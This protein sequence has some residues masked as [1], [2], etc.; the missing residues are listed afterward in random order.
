[1]ADISQR[2]VSKTQ[3]RLSGAGGTSRAPSWDDLRTLLA[4][5][6]AGSFRKGAGKLGVDVATAMRRV[7]R[8]E[9]ALD[10]KIVDR[11]PHGLKVLP[12]GESVLAEIKAMEQAAL[13]IRREAGPLEP[14][15]RGLVRVA[16]TEGL[17]TFWVLPRLLEFQ[18]AHRYL[19]FE[20]QTT[21]G[22]TDVGK[23]E[24]DMSV[25]FNRPERQDL[26]AVQI[27]YLHTYP[28]ASQGYARL[29]GL[30][31]SLAELR[32]H[33]YIAQITPTLQTEVYEDLL[34][35][36]S[37]EGIVGVSA[38]ASS[39]ILYAVERDAGIALLPNYAIALGANLVPVDIGM[40]NRLEL[41][42]T[43]HPAHRK[44]QRHMTIVSWLRRIFD[45][46]R[47][48][49]FGAKF[50][51]P[52]ELPALMDEASRNAASIEGFATG[53]PKGPGRRSRKQR[54]ETE[55]VCE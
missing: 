33:R 52:L 23:L 40:K 10:M 41:W 26:V 25:Q 32:N 9:R 55:P 24:A 27:G 28:F 29:Y 18:K 45:Y 47:F 31:K 1:M 3:R 22:F 4:C 21:M 19:T 8:L 34:G 14:S 35:V 48:P 36:D 11:L 49:C 50:I 5:V 42:L 17:G 43:Y 51:H 20:L 46:S 13:N 53:M 6:E 54:T 7:D 2:G 16:I 12:A 39:S 37:L 30:P 44:S 38:N 15:L